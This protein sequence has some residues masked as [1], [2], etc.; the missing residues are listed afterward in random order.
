MYT[1]YLGQNPSAGRSAYEK[2]QKENDLDILLD[3]IAMHIPM[4]L[5]KRQ[6]VLECFD[7][8][9]RF[10]LVSEYLAREIDIGQIRSG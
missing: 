10:Y 2:I 5:E 3:L 6:Q 9:N 7:V 8:E 1:L 4:D